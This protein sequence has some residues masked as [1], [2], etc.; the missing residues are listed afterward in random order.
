MHGTNTMIMVNCLPFSF[1]CRCNQDAI[2]NGFDY[3]VLRYFGECYGATKVSTL[4][5]NDCLS[6]GY[7]TCIDSSDK[8]C[9]G[10]SL[11]DYIYEV[12]EGILALLCI[13]DL[14]ILSM[15]I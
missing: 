9:V 6:H 10:V 13:V 11:V 14:T 15:I 5:S 2:A 4:A 7:E 1:A 12:G 8:E 3:F